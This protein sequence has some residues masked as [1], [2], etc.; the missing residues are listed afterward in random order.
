MAWSS[1]GARNAHNQD[2]LRRAASQVVTSDNELT[3]ALESYLENH[4]LHQEERK[5][6]A[7]SECEFLDGNAT[8]R[9]AL[10]ILEYYTK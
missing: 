4:S 3:K 8:Q 5:A 6:Y 2:P 7:L 9:L 10:M 1:T